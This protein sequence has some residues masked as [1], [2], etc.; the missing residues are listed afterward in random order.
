MRSPILLGLV[1]SSGPAGSCNKNKHCDSGEFCYSST[2]SCSNMNCAC[3]DCGDYNGAPGLHLRARRTATATRTSAGATAPSP[4]RRRPTPRPVAVSTPRPTARPT[5]RDPAADPA[6]DPR[7]TPRPTPRPIAAGSPTP[8]PA[9]TIVYDDDDDDYTP[10]Y[11][12]AVRREPRASPSL[13]VAVPLGRLHHVHGRRDAPYEDWAPPGGSGTSYS[14]VLDPGDDELWADDD[15]ARGIGAEPLPL[16]DGVATC[17]DVEADP[18]FRDRCWTQLPQMVQGCGPAWK[19]PRLAGTRRRPGSGGGSTVPLRPSARAPA[20][21]APA[22]SGGACDAIDVAGTDYGLVTGFAYDGL[23]E[24]AGACNGQPYYKCTC[25]TAYDPANDVDDPDECLSEK[26]FHHYVWYDGAAWQLR[27]YA[28]GAG[29]M[30]GWDECGGGSGWGDEY[31]LADPD[32]DLAAASV[33]GTWEKQ[34]SDLAGDVVYSWN[35]HPD[36]HLRG[37]LVGLG[38]RGLQRDPRRRAPGRRSRRS[39]RWR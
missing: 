6:P 2:N 33:E 32:G 14:Y 37:G 5:R 12:R 30:W 4:R 35:A 28:G 20:H 29:D 3:H 8:R 1:A 19:V 24:E 11:S 15:G 25:C 23:Y 21:A 26:D 10:T 31:R 36:G 22:A 39:C 27:L 17:G 18:A 34:D 9:A 16:A 38:H 7:P 13:R